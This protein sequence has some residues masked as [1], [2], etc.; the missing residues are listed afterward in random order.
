MKLIIK[1]LVVIILSNFINISIY[2]QNNILEF[3]FEGNTKSENHEFTGKGFTFVDGIDDQ[4]LSIQSGNNE[5]NYLTLQDLSFDQK[6]SFTIQFWINSKSKKPTV[7]ISQK[8]F[9]NKGINAQKN[10]GWVLYSSN[11]TLAWSIGS[12][13]RRL[14]YERDNDDKVRLAD[15]IWHQ[16]TMTYNKESSEVRLYQD[17]KN[18]AIYKVG[19]DFINT[20][21]VVIGTHENNFDYK[22]DI[23]ADIEKGVIQLQKLVDEFNS[24]GL[25]NVTQ[26][27]FFSLIVDPK[28]LYLSKLKIEE[29][30]RSK[31]R[32]QKLEL[33]Q[34]ISDSHDSLYYNA[35]TVS[36][37]HELTAL[38]PVSKIYY[39]KN[40]VVYINEFY[41]KQFGEKEQLYPSNF[42]IDKLTF[43][44]QSLCPEDVWKSFIKYKHVE[45]I[46]LEKKLD[47]LTV[48]VWNIWHGGIHFSLNEHGWDSRLKI[49]KML[50]NSNV[51]IV[52]MQET[53]SSGGYIAAELGYYF[54]T[55]SDWDYC[56]QGSN[57]SVLSRY[58]IKELEV[59][60]DAEFMNISAKI[61]LSETQEIYAMSNWY[62]MSSFPKV[63][64]F[65][66]E[67]FIKSD[68][69]PILFGGD[70]NAIPHTDGG[71][72]EASV[73]LLENEFKDAYRY[74]HPDVKTFPGYTHQWGERIDQLYYKGTGLEIINSKV[75]STAFGGFPSDHFMILSKFKLN[76]LDINIEK[77]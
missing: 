26:E 5:Y 57:I 31:L 63:Y 69:T 58:P 65:H 28:E 15:G 34:K 27:E 72:S 12:G 43:Y 68:K 60:Q 14:N 21:P 41:A 46:T 22:N 23:L 62:G 70:F 19:F 37:N 4:S 64:E 1:Y 51:D 25:G 67:K 50:K 18:I 71:D 49:A 29:S 52:L 35:Y 3:D 39:L 66:E 7:L 61:K 32:D 55:T 74:L 53:Y 75:V 17:G 48:A 76:F 54:A 73:K 36:Q 16:I 2:G 24:L 33:F 8:K 44:D 42:S 77:D 59:S 56:S 13:K 38:K 6:A 47:T 40:D 45:G 9:L 10:K 11:G 20:N 30:K